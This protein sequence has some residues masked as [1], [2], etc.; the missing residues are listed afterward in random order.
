MKK[1]LRQFPQAED[2]IISLEKGGAVLE[3][4]VVVR[5]QAEVGLAGFPM[6]SHAEVCVSR[7]N[8]IDWTRLAD[9][10]VHSLVLRGVVVVLDHPLVQANPYREELIP[11]YNRILMERK[12][13]Q[14][15][16]H[17]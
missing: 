13:W 4:R 16:S 6:V 9:E 7:F 1:F 10:L 3:G 15:K 12:Q 2:L 14:E 5:L 8:G 17:G 11:V